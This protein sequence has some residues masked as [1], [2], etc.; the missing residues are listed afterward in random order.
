MFH[1]VLKSKVRQKT[2]Q[3]IYCLIYKLGL[4]RNLSSSFMRIFYILLREILA[5]GDV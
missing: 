5:A 3:I 2:Q 1:L 4:Y